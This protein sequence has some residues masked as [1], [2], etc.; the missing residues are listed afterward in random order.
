[1]NT[2]GELPELP[3]NSSPL[4]FGDW[5]HLIAP[6][7]KDISGAA[8]WWWENTLREAKAYYETWKASSPL[9]RIQ[10]QPVLP[11][12]LREHHFQRT[13]QRGIQML[14][15]AIPETEQQALVTER[16]LSTTAILYRL[17]VRFQPGG[18]G[19]K[20][21][22]LQQLTSIPKA[23]NVQDLAASLRN[24]RRHF[25]RAEEVNATLPDGVLLLKALDSPLQQLGTMDPQA[26]FRLSQS[27]MQLQLDQQPS[28]RNLWA[29]SQCLLAEAETLALLQMSSATAPSTP[30]KLKVMDG[31]PK[32]PPRAIGADGKGGSKPLS[33]KPCKYFISDAG[34]KAG[35]AC[36][37]LHSWEGVED[38]ASRCWICGGKDH[39]KNDCKLRSTG[40]SGSG[41][42]PGGGRGGSNGSNAAGGTTSSSSTMATTGGGKAGAAAAVK[43]TKTSGGEDASS[44]VVTEGGGTMVEKSCSATSGDNN[45]G[46]PGGGGGEATSKT[47]QTAELL[48]EAT[49]LLKKL[50]IPGGPKLKVMQL[51]D[52]DPVRDGMILLDSGATHALRP[53]RDADEWQKAERTVVQLA[54]GSTESFRLKKGTRILLSHP[55]EPAASIIPMSGINDLD[56][57]LEWRD[58]QCRLLDDENRLIPV[59]LQN[60][61]PMVE[62][63]QG[64]KLL[65]WLEAYQVYQRRKLAV[66]KT[67]MSDA[68]LVDSSNMTMDMA[69]TL[70]IRQE[71]PDLPDHVLLKLV[72][73]L[74]VVKAEDFGA[75]LPW[76]RH[77]RRRLLKAKHIAKHIVLHLFSGPDQKFWEKRCSTATTEVL[78][79]DTCGST[80][81]NL[82]DRNVFGF[83]LALCASGHVK[84]I[85]G[86]PPCRTV[87][88]L[89]YQNDGGPGI[90]RDQHPYGLPDLGPADADLVLGDVVLWYRM[91]ALYIIAED[92]RLADQPQTQLVLEQPED[93]ARHRDPNDVAEHKYFSNFRTAEWRM[94]Q[95]RYGIQLYHF[96]QFPMGHIKRKPTTLAT[97]MTELGQLDNLRGGP[98]NESLS[99]EQFKALS[100]DERCRLTKTRAAWAPGLKEAIATEV[101]RFIQ[102]VERD[103]HSVQPLALGSADG[104]DCDLSSVQPR[105]GRGR[106]HRRVTHPDAYALSVDLSGKL[107]A[108]FDQGHQR[109]RYL[110]V[111]CF[112][113]PVTGDGA[114][115]VNPPGDPKDEK[116]HP[117]PSMDLHGR[118]D[119]SSGDQ[120]L[121]GEWIDDDVV[122]MDEGGDAPPA[123][124]DPSDL[125]DPDDPLNER[126]HPEE[127]GDGPVHDSMRG[128]Y[129]V[130]H[131]MVDEAKNVGVKNL[132]FVEVMN[133]RSV[134]DV[135]PALARIH[136]RLC[137]LGLPL[138][139]IHCDRARELTAA[140][141]R[142]WTLDRG[143]IT[144][145]T[146]GSSYK[147]NGRVEAEV[148]ATKRAIRTLISAGLCPLDHW[149][150]AARHIGERRLRAQ[151]QR[152]GWPASPMLAFGSKAFALRKSWQERYSQW[153]DCR[154]EVRIMGPD[155]CSSLTTTSYYV[156][157]TQTG[158]FFY[159]DDVVQPPAD[160]PLA[161]LDVQPEAPAIYLEERGFQPSAPLWPGAPTR[162][163]RGKQAVP[164]I[165]SLCYSEGEMPSVVFGLDAPHV[166]QVHQVCHGSQGSQDAQVCQGSRGSQDAQ[167]CQ[168]PQVSQ[169]P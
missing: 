129:T 168:E 102:G 124:E 49:Q 169:V 126:S 114:P 59:T 117:L 88:A 138:L 147:A 65:E 162:R 56:F 142:R 41:A 154:E 11:D 63:E 98:P 122:M 167:V 79:V 61:C 58:G 7:M 123:P 118:G 10:I 110:M 8:G 151:L 60:G 130:W 158:R 152:V 113:F 120:E 94:F 136:A 137:A 149:P 156:Q 148:G 155:K 109:C 48:H 35:K 82:H 68:E 51:G 45:D 26:A 125:P 21:I 86:G 141:V 66:V 93:P 33:E 144:T 6:V 5:L 90:L 145:L 1:M 101:G 47:S 34:C 69:I 165:R 74:D 50:Q 115:L 36:K 37:W 127:A 16:A 132:T 116:D 29:F 40:Q 163:L 92:V 30:L 12:A 97:T 76:N 91:L 44:T 18:A 139:R 31:D 119:P 157:S 106:Q 161:L 54:N 87:S 27:R 140:S 24:W 81:V 89:R 108:G 57:S 103:P 15:K 146:T 13:E 95:Q 9:Q 28:H 14:L 43:V 77:R 135:M 64:E 53:A 17:L 105:A 85:L 46:N 42:G 107:T 73:H 78:C 121:P 166:C 160:A 104:S 112:T 67:M 72:P 164:A 134:K 55:D 52:V 96:D 75:R 153:R 99:A 128:A 22:L 3:A 150:L 38:K 2:K 100:M 62:R 25:G 131:R 84:A 83:L 143:I 70:K 20:Q 23:A 4:Q 80:P 71:F 133:S 19:E 32:T 111:A 39:R 159:T